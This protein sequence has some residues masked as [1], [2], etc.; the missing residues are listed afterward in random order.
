MGTDKPLISILMA[1]YEP[2]MDWLR[3][4]LDSLNAQTYPNLRLYARD[5]CSPRVPF[6]DI[7]ALV[8]QCITAFPYTIERNEEN[9]GSNKTFERL[10]QE[11]EG[12]Y[13]AY[14]D[15]DDVWLPEK[16]SVL[17]E[18]IQRERAEL[19]YS[20]MAVIG[21]RGEPIGE[22][23]KVIRPRL[24]YVSGAGLA[25]TYF[26]RNCTAGCSMLVCAETAKNAAPFPRL[27]VCDQ[28]LSISASNE[29]PV[30]FVNRPLV[31]YRQH[32]RNQTGILTGVTDKKSYY[33]VRL[34]PLRERLTRYQQAFGDNEALSSF[35]EARLRG[36]IRQIWKY[37]VFSP[38][39]AKF[40]IAMRCM[41][42][43]LFQQ[44][45]RKLL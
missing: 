28:W 1:V 34:E 23:L 37:R 19:A 31:R 30:A 15:Q 6:D 40:E 17:E 45:V 25:D 9:L 29:G 27:T 38:V 5:D 43:F 26:F 22:S 39:E 32:K 18:A 12:K 36:R 20:D 42:N 13:F 11:A 33:Q 35:V 16:L 14:C 21:E 4:Q 41:P 24:R 7:K 44:V 2:R 8:A 10:T 3:E